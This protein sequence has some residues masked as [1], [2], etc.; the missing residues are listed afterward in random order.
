MRLPA[1]LLLLFL[2]LVSNSPVQAQYV[3]VKMRD[4][5]AQAS[6]EAAAK[7]S[8]DAAAKDSADAVKWLNRGLEEYNLGKY[9]QAASSLSIAVSRNPQSD[10]AH[11]FLANALWN[12]RQTNRALQEYQ[13]ALENSQSP[14]MTENCHSVLARYHFHTVASAARAPLSLLPTAPAVTDISKM[15]S[16]TGSIRGFEPAI[17]RD[18]SSFMNAAAGSGAGNLRTSESHPD[19]VA[20]FNSAPAQNAS[21]NSWQMRFRLSFERALSAEL[22]KRNVIG[23]CGKY[24]MIFSCDSSRQLRGKIVDTNAPDVVN[25]SLLAA[26]KQLDGSRVLEFPDDIGSS[27]FNFTLAWDNPVVRS[28]PQS[29][30]PRTGADILVRNYASVE[31]VPGYFAN[32]KGVIVNAKG[33]KAIPGRLKGDHSSTRDVNADLLRKNGV[34]AVTAQLPTSVEAVI[35]E[36]PPELQGVAGVLPS[37]DLPQFDVVVSGKVLPRPAPIALKTTQQLQSLDA[38]APART[39]S[40]GKK[41]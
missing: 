7:A 39:S 9:A 24:S 27:G 4:S 17:R 32:T 30:L 25:E 35:G 21:F 38:L 23:R 12:T 11:Y 29:P 19:G 28:A 3:R 15:A 14:E 2:T 8:A 13:R 6:A 18:L 10:K 31:A 37:S 26:T 16:G 1:C 33:L 40:A 5:P 22:N 20:V 36:F 34:E 41:R